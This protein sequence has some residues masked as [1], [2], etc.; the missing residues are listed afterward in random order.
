M[1]MNRHFGRLAALLA[2]TLL[3]GCT[4]APG[5][6][7][8]TPQPEL[9]A[10]ET[11]ALSGPAEPAPTAAP[12]QEQTPAP[13]PAPEEA[14]PVAA[15]LQQ[16]TLREKVGQLFM[17]RPDSLDLTLP[18]EEIDDE[19]AD[20]VTA[21]SDAMRKTLQ[22]Y[23]VGGI[24]QFGKNITDPQQIAQF[25]ADLQ[26]ASKIPLLI[27][28]DEEGGVV[29]RLAN[30]P[31]FDLPRYESAAAI[32]ETGD[33][34]AAR[35]MGATI[36]AYLKDYGFTMDFA[37]DADVYTNPANT[38]IGTRAFSQDAATAATMAGAMAQGL[39]AQGILPTLKHFP[40]HGDTAEDS[41][42]GLAYSHRT[43][44]EMLQC[45]F[46]PF[47]QPTQ[48]EGGIGPHAI[49]VGHIAAP[50]LD[51]DTPASLSYPIVT[52]LLRGE[53]LQGEDVLVV[54]DSLAMGAITEQYAPAE[55]AIRALN[56]GCDILL[57][58]DGLTEAFDGV[59]AA[60]ENGTISEE[61]LNESVA[62]ILRVKQQYAG[63]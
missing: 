51:G 57:M 49:M 59:V 26:A 9:P 31:A 47:M 12:A 22:D 50:A 7:Q 35:E 61:R 41:H 2:L 36:G 1:R 56:A 24:C 60:V 16:M 44:E 55:A 6:A 4:P 18:Q 37:P 43:K 32:G 30:H 3:C 13:E 34:E 63:L 28:V 14:D 10:T 27:S 8:P 62:R 54:T 21:L 17:I 23:P 40:G 33:P 53:L 20:G 11:P 39:Q 19:Y 5:A 29:A 58:P 46:L 42:S 25:N 52:G 48:G 45:E 38:V 15:L